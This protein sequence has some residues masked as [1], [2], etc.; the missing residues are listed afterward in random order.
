MVENE[1]K[2]AKKKYGH[3]NSTHEIYGVLTEEVEEFWEIVKE[4]NHK[5]DDEY[6]STRMISELSQVAAI[7]LRAIDELKNNK[8]KWI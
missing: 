6:K 5:M 1:I 2:N 3:F 8:I 4:P 7:S